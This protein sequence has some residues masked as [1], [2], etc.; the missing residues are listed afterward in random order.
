MAREK[1]IC[2]IN[3][4]SGIAV[5]KRHYKLEEVFGMQEKPPQ[6]CPTYLERSVHQIFSN[7]ISN[8]NIIVIYGESRQGKTWMIEKYC[9]NQI[10]IGCTSDMNIILLK[11][12]MLYNLGLSVLK[13][14]HTVTKEQVNKNNRK[15]GK[16]IKVVNRI[17]YLCF[18]MIHITKSC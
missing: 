5:T 14:E 17:L 3:Q 11:E 15:L 7:T 10:R 16:K 13:V 9:R 4:K 8:T 1:E 12:A 6:P 18:I 2:L